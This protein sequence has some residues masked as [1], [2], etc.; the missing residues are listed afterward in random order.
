M[1]VNICGP[2]WFLA[3]V[4]GGSDRQ[5]GREPPR[6]DVGSVLM[7]E[8]GFLVG[9]FI[10]IALAVIVTGKEVME[11]GVH[12]PHLS[13]NSSSSSSCCS[14]M[15][16]S[17]PLSSSASTLAVMLISSVPVVSVANMKWS[18]FMEL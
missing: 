3:D 13:S 8:S 11:A 1:E 6:Q 17:T 10:I 7:C 14:C 4:G 15:A 12:V 16:V 5:D 18:K 2:I 9:N